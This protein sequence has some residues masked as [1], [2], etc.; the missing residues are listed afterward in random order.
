M[1]A[2]QAQR[3]IPATTTRHAF[4][5]SGFPKFNTDAMLSP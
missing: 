5:F 1:P 3:P 4:L 2:S